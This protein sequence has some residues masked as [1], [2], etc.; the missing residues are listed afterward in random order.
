MNARAAL[1]LILACALSI[2][3]AFAVPPPGVWID[4]PFVAQT[5]DG[6]GSAAISMVLQY[7]EKQTGQAAASST[8]PERIQSALYSRAA[9]GIPASKM[10]EYFEAAGYRVFAF[11]GGWNDLRHHVQQGRP[12]IV[13]LKASGPLGPL[14][15]VVVT[16]IDAERGYV[17]L[18]DPAQQKSLRMSREGFESE[19]NPT[20][21][22]TLL[23]VPQ[24]SD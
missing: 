21:H 3:P 18:N 22:W 6:C 1:S 4:V 19:W 15:Y 8:D 16:G 11:Q 24:S 12:L 17:Y 7:W 9:G 2:I 20:H 5:R 23:A 10:R 13:M 14:H